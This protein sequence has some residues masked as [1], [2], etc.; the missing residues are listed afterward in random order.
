MPVSESIIEFVADRDALQR[1]Y[2]ISLSLTRHERLQKLYGDWMKRVNAI[3]FDALSF[4]DRVDYT[5][6]KNHLLRELRNLDLAAVKAGE[7]CPLLPFAPA[8]IE[9]AEARQKVEPL[10]PAKAA[11]TLAAIAKACDLA[12]DMEAKA[13]VANRAIRE[14]EA[15]AEALNEWYEFYTGYDPL[16]TWWTAEPYKAA[17]KA[18]TD[19]PDALRAKFLGGQSEGEGAI[20]GDPVGRE[21]LLADLEFDL[22][23]YSPE[24]LLEIGEKE[25]AWCEA[26]MRKASA[27]LGFGD[28]WKAALEHVKDLYAAP[29]DQ[30]RIVKELAEEAIDYVKERD[31]ITVPDLAAETWRMSMMSPEKQKINPFF[32]GG[33]QIIVSYPTDTMTHAE[34]LMSMR[35]NN[36]HFSR[37]TVQHELI[38]GHH[39]QFFML[40]RHRPY[41]MLFETPF[42]IEG[43]T[44][45]WEMLLWDL[46]FPRGAEDRVGMLFW[47]MHRCARIVFSI[48]FHL[49]QMSAEECVNF[50]VDRVGHERANAEGEVRRSFKGDYPPLYQ[51]AYMIGGLQVMAMHRE[52]VDSGKMTNREFH[53]RFLEQN[54]MPIEILRAILSGEG[55]NKDFRSSWR[56]AG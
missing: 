13:T 19:Y 49:G 42:W 44:L 43:W 14:T 46:G 53:D 9:L 4:D 30:I 15:L 31:L 17:E 35:G 16:F 27:E 18:L 5:L 41:R 34:K 32:L 10:D 1:F 23:P 29:G 33:E 56:F 22:I 51:A 54:M 21:G 25:F 3:D 24:E 7:V 2:P 36:P 45:Y 50:L 8:I 52:L 20:I 37:A 6:F 26:E 47:R 38:P 28:D 55:V 12:E 48:K 39:L 40:E 11:E